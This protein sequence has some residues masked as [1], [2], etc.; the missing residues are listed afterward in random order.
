MPSVSY[1][2]ESAWKQYVNLV[3]I[4]SEEFKNLHVLQFDVLH[5]NLYQLCYIN[6]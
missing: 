6:L 1:I 5:N 2:I 3:K 4:Y